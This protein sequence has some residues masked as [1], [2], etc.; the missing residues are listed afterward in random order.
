[1]L[2]PLGKCPRI[3]G[4]LSRLLTVLFF[5]DITN[6]PSLQVA[7]STWHKFENILKVSCLFEY[8]IHFSLAFNKIPDKCG[9]AKRL[10]R[11]D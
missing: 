4:I 5:S 6:N 11:A 3:T 1:M 10:K 8:R 7:L 2:V 9:L